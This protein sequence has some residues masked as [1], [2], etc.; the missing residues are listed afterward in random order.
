[1]LRLRPTGYLPNFQYN[2]AGS[3]YFPIAIAADNK[4]LYLSDYNR[5]RVL[6]YRT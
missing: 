2:T 3:L 4:H 5:C 6:I 1:M